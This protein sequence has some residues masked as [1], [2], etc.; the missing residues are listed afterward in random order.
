M[1]YIVNCVTFYFYVLTRLR[2]M[3]F[4]NFIFLILKKLVWMFR[5][6]N[7]RDNQNKQVNKIDSCVM[8]PSKSEMWSQLTRESANCIF[9]SIYFAFVQGNIMLSP[10]TSC[11]LL[12]ADTYTATD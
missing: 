2:P 4:I 10:Q 3:V 9:I 6:K 7:F 11:V 5:T 1:K 12:L 8:S